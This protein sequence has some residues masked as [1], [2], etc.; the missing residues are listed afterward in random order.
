MKIP[1][2][3][4]K[5][6]WKSDNGYAPMSAELNPFSNE[7]TPELEDLIYNKFKNNKY[8]GFIVTTTS[9]DYDASPEGKQFIC[10]GEFKVHP[11]YGEQF[12]SEF[13]YEDIPTTTEG[14]K[15]LL[16][17]FPH[18]K[19]FRAQTIIDT[20]GVQGIIDILDKEPE[21][22]LE[23]NGINKKRLPAIIEE[24]AK[25][26]GKKDLIV[27]LAQHKAGSAK[28]ATKIYEK[29][30]HNSQTILSENPYLI[31]DIK[32]IGFIES[33]DFAHKIL[34]DVPKQYRMTACMS[35]VLAEALRSGGNLYMPYSE[36]KDKVVDTIMEIDS[37]KG[38]Q[39]KSSD[40]KSLFNTCIKANLDKFS[41]L[42]EDKGVYI[43]LKYIYEA[44]KMISEELF[45][46]S[47]AE[48]HQKV[49]DSDILDVERDISSLAGKEIKLDDTQKEAIRSVFENKVT[50]ITGG[51]GTG[52]STICRGIYYLAC[53][54]RRTIRLMSPTGKASQVLGKK[55]QAPAS[56]IHRSLKMKPGD[57][58]PVEKIHE[59]IVLIDEFSMVG[60]DTLQAI[61]HAM[62][63]NDFAHLVLVGD[64]NQL[65][66]VSPGNFLSD[67]SKSGC[68]NV[69]K[70]DKI[71]RQDENS[72]IAV[73]AQNIANG[74]VVEN[75]PAEAND[76]SWKTSDEEQ[77]EPH[78]TY[79]I[80]TYL[81]DHE[82]D[83]VQIIAPMYKG[84]AG[85]TNINTVVQNMMVQINNT[86]D[87]ELKRPYQLFYE[88]DRVIQW[89]NNYEKEV[90]NGDIGTI[91]DLGKRVMDRERNS[92]ES[93]Y[94]VVKFDN[95][96]KTYIGHE[97]D[98]L[99]LAWCVSVHKYQ[100]SQSPYIIFVMPSAANRMASKELVYTAM[101]R[102]EKYLY[103]LG[104]IN[105]FRRAP[106]NSNIT[107]RNTNMV[108]FIEE[109][110][111][112]KK[113]FDVLK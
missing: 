39:S 64:A 24:W 18:V 63:N 84:Q 90:F 42:K 44:E 4:K 11:K 79:L 71:H 62:L 70:L 106:M 19:E 102:A 26:K 77:L 68:A 91:V 107:K 76:I 94:I 80:N 88:K 67:I 41:A 7:Y 87:T 93:D 25:L 57:S 85:I 54:N 104:D 17:A 99:K 34:K 72:Y 86:R 83:D 1:V 101:T 51:G 66:S 111:D 37:K 16:M 32:G 52:K 28:L 35:Y 22:L 75:I 36:L 81:K 6:L 29:W 96:E 33:D 73:I 9:L 50:I 105:I 60:I 82:I 65:P 15:M 89:E 53:K 43:Y 92:S 27:W 2:I 5:I 20:F 8:D 97:I 110:R 112:N 21:R 103:M 46:R 40:Y 12:Q 78:L 59:D 95:D 38:T 100:G 13:F 47:K 58:K 55:T 108:K 56:T 3:I 31:S 30:K 109:L 49:T 69:V 23:I 10:E 74:K 45:K 48:N 61:F 14:F 113:I 98:Q